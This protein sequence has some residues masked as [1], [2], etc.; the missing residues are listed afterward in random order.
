M[1]GLDILLFRDEKDANVIRKSLEKRF[2]DPKL[3]DLII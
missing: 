2:R 1:G 3:V